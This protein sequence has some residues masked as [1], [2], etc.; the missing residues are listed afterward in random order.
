MENVAEIVINKLLE[1]GFYDVLIFVIALAVLYGI[2][3]KVKFFGGSTIVNVALAFS[4]AFLI[5]GFPIILNYSLILPMAKFFMHSFLWILIFF[6]GMLVASFFYPDL[7]TFLTEKFTSRSVFYITIAIGVATAV[8][9]GLVSV[10]W[11]APPSDESIS[12]SPPTD[13]VIVAAGVIIFVILLV[14]AGSIALR[15]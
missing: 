14:I 8:I 4:V 11:A 5:F 10:L 1:V 2:L 3:D 7:P 9:S 13:V 15:Q 12:A 6:V